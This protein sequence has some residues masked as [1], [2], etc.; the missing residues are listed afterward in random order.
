VVQG[1]Y[2]NFNRYVSMSYTGINYAEYVIRILVAVPQQYVNTYSTR[3][4]GRAAYLGG[5]T[6]TPFAFRSAM[7]RQKEPLEHRKRPAVPT[8][9]LDTN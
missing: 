6:Y 4:F 3:S 1:Y 5:L 2:I 7:P 8:P 9:V